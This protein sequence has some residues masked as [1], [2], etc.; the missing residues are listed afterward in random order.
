[1]RTLCSVSCRF[2][3]KLSDLLSWIKTWKTSAQALA[4]THPETTPDAPDLQAK[5]KVNLPT[6]NKQFHLKVGA[7]V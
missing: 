4:S 1:M 7:Y 3:K 6:Q 5:L 2:E